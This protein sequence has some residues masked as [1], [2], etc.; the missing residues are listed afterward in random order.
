M[1]DDRETVSLLRS[2]A[3]KKNFCFHPTA[4]ATSFCQTHF[5]YGTS[6]CLLSWHCAWDFKLPLELALYMGLQNAFRVG[7]VHGTSKCL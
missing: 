7:T 1:M 5:H 6:K 2:L 4:R 3:D